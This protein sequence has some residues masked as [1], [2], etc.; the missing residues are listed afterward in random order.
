MRKLIVLFTAL[1]ALGCGPGR[2]GFG[3]D[4]GSDAGDGGDLDVTQGDACPFC[5]VDSGTKEAGQYA[6]SG[7]LRN[8]IDGQGNVVMTCPDDQG[9]AGGGCV[10]ACQ[11]A[12]ASKGSVGCDYVVPTPSFY[13]YIAPPCW[14]VFV[15]NNWV[16]PVQLT[17]ARAG[18][19]YNATQFGRI[20]K[21]GT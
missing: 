20:A 10:P 3:D 4:G 17:V 9:C 1:F 7:D 21:A 15:A 8:V 16:K 11:A 13:A 5:G 19:T 14:A 12:G 6:C 2:I 18:K